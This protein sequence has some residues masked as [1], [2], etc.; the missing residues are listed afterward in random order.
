[1]AD[2]LTNAFTFVNRY[3]I[4]EGVRLYAQETWRQVMKDKGRQLVARHIDQVRHGSQD[5]LNSL[6]FNSLVRF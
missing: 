3:Y 4:A 5:W 2:G 6:L 1:M